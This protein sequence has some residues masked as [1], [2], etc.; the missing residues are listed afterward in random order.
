MANLTSLSIDGTLIRK[1]GTESGS[2]SVSTTAIQGTSS[3]LISAN[4]INWLAGAYTTS[5]KSVIAYQDEQ[6][7][8]Y[9]PCKAR[10]VTVTGSTISYGTTATL[11]GGNDADD[12]GN[13]INLCYF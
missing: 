9:G 11:P 1:E 5:G 7:G 8:Y 4:T 6:A 2:Q 3:G 10:V 12:A 13:R